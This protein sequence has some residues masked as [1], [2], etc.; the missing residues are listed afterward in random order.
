MK[1]KMG[2]GL[3]EQDGKTILPIAIEEIKY[4]EASR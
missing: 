4:K 1:E 3:T 2:S